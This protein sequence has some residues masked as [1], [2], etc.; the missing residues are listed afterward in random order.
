M[1]LLSRRHPNQS[2][3]TLFEA[4]I[5]LAILSLLLAVAVSSAKPPSPALRAKS[6]AARLVRTAGQV[7]LT[8]IE[9][10]STKVWVPG[11]VACDPDEATEY[12]FFSDGTAIG[13]DLC[14]FDMRLELHPLTGFLLEVKS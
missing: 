8:A 11:V 5:S 10:Q 14:L 12:Q 4:L 3:F 1:T 6:N 9:T 2:G 13:P 7:R